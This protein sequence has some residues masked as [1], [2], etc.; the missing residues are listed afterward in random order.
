MFERSALQMF[1]EG[2]NT[3]GL[4]VDSAQWSEC[5]L[6]WNSGCEL[7]LQKRPEKT[8]KVVIVWYW[9][10]DSEKLDLGDT[11]ALLYVALLFDILKSKFT[12]Y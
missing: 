10:W 7:C 3:L 4:Y 12:H 5:V 9:L 8:P 11:A 1:Y 2:I 6:L